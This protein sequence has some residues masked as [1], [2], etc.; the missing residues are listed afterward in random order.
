[1]NHFTSAV[2][3]PIAPLK[4]LYPMGTN[5]T[6]TSSVSTKKQIWKHTWI[7]VNGCVKL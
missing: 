6:I 5:L 7:F 3:F 2:P 1:V 4:G